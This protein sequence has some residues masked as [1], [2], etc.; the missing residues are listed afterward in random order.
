MQSYRVHTD[1]PY[2]TSKATS[3]ELY[4]WLSQN[5][6]LFEAKENNSEKSNA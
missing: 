4:K 6:M 1:F 3:A 5:F 2:L